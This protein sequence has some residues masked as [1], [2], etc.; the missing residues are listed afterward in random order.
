MN[1]K[2][3]YKREFRSLSSVKA[4]QDLL[5]QSLCSVR[6]Y[7]LLSEIFERAMKFA[8]DDN[9][10]WFQFALSLICLGRYGRAHVIL[11]QCLSPDRN[12]NVAKGGA[13]DQIRVQN[14]A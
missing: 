12:V 7:G 11:K 4:V 10:I 1:S 14:Q 5:T 13:D 6:Q 3:N 8:Y 9:F 2:F